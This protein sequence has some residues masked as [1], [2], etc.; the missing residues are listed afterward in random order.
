MHLNLST[1]EKSSA[2]YDLHRISSFPRSTSST[3]YGE[4]HKTESF[5]VTTSK[6]TNYPI[7]N[8]FKYTKAAHDPIPH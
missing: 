1:L 4:Y 7:A 8:N 3:F 2:S 5:F 6:I